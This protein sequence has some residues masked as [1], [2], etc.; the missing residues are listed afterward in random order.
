MKAVDTIGEV[1]I[2]QEAIIEWARINQ[3]PVG[4]FAVL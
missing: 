2:Q 1:I 3:S 4:Y